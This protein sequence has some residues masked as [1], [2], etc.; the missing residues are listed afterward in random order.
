ML[1]DIDYTWESAALQRMP[2]PECCPSSVLNLCLEGD[3]IIL[4]FSS[5]K[6][7][8]GE[9]F[10]ISGDYD[11]I[12]L[13]KDYILNSRCSVDGHIIHV[14]EEKAYLTYELDDQDNLAATLHLTFN[15]EQEAWIKFLEKEMHQIN[16]AGNFY[17]VGSNFYQE[18]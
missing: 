7:I 1:R 11:A 12:N 10:N 18:S 14:V 6:L 16:A 4:D 17:W 5:L 8:D 13:I 9:K 3:V 2:S 15:Y